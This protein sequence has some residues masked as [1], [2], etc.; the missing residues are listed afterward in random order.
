LRPSARIA[1]NA[2]DFGKII[3]TS[4]NPRLIQLALKFDF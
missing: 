2:G 4:N 1:N 3:S